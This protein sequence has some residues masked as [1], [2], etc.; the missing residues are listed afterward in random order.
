MITYS[1]SNAW[2]DTPSNDTV[3]K[4]YF[5]ASLHTTS[6][7]GASA[8][9]KFNGTGIWLYGGHRS[10]YGNYQIAV[11][12]KKVASGSAKSSKTQVKQAL[13]GS[14]GLK[15]GE[16]TVTLTNEGGGP[17]DVDELIFET[18]A[19]TAGYVFLTFVLASGQVHSS[20]GSLPQQCRLAV[21]LSVYPSTPCVLYAE[22]LL[23]CIDVI[24]SRKLLRDDA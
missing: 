8:S 22:V 18:T 1:P 11:D 6:T 7:K 12:G 2:T 5:D 23:L 9:F 19:G 14:S 24:E 15:M 17:I 16:H 13:G 21:L 10:N 3:A 20:C 4:T